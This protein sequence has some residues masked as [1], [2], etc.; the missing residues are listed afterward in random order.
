MFSVT[1]L[2]ITGLVTPR[3]FAADTAQSA[4]ESKSSS[5]LIS[6][7]DEDIRYNAYLQEIEEAAKNNNITIKDYDGSD[8]VLTPADAVCTDETEDSTPDNPIYV[9][10]PLGEEA[11]KDNIIKGTEDYTAFTWTVNVP[12]TG[13]Y[14]IAID[15]IGAAD[16][17]GINPSRGIA[18]NGKI[19]FF[20]AI[21]ISFKKWW[22]DSSE[23]IENELTHDETAAPLEE[24]R[25][26]ATVDLRDTDGYYTAPFK[27]YLEA[28]TNTITLNYVNRT[29]FVGNLYLKAPQKLQDYATVSAGYSEYDASGIEKQTFQAEDISKIVEK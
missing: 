18:I 5:E 10:T 9:E 20:E 29:M 4:G 13:Y 15:Y 6:V 21:N 19:P 16:G 11:G 25:H 8:I 1:T 14:Q 26:W 7:G 12:K 24:I 28:G 3:A 23:P 17:L 22:K 27:F 2:I